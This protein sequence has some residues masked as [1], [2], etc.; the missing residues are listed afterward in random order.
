MNKELKKYLNRYNEQLENLGIKD[1]STDRI[2]ALFSKNKAGLNNLFMA[3]MGA[4]TLMLR[5]GAVYHLVKKLDKGD[6]QDDALLIKQIIDNLRENLPSDT[7]WKVIWEICVALDDNKWQEPINKTK[8]EQQNILEK[9]ITFRNKYVHSYIALEEKHIKEISK[10][11]VAINEMCE[12]HSILFSGFNLSVKEGKY[13]LQ[14]NNKEYCLHPF[15][16]KGAQDSPYIF[17]GLYNNKEVPELIGIEYGDTVKQDT[18]K[19]YEE[20]FEPLSRTLKSGAGQVFDHSNKINYYKEC[21]VGRDRENDAIISWAKQTDENNV[22]TVFSDAGMGK[23]ALMANVIDKLRSKEN[24]IPVLYHFCG[25]GV[26]NSL[27]A[28]LYHLIIQGQK[29]PPNGI[30]L[31]KSNDEKIQRKLNRLPSRYHD[32]IHLFQDLLDG[33]FNPPKSLSQGN[34]VVLIDGLD[35]AA[36]AYANY[37][38]SDWFNK[39]DDKG[40]VESSWESAKNIRW[41][42]TYRKGF[43]RFPGNLK[44][45]QIDL[46]QPLQGLTPEAAREALKE[47]NPS[48][49]FLDEVIKRGSVA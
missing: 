26:Q 29:Y 18:N 6:I 27:H 38:I 33:C 37:H 8:G 39:Y 42:F 12:K 9:F 3:G 30:S 10:G 4:C 41:I 19:A 7:N 48:E 49:E 31:W 40:E 23:G 17:Q 45:T 32:V 24:Q 34:L 20:V 44:Q 36:V 13:Y 46:L 14:Y 21:F 16:Q 2:L 22:L 25:S 1:L 43:Y 28:T 11:L 35:E 47:F 5:L 15:I